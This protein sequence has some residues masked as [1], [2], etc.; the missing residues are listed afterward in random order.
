[1]ISRKPK[2]LSAAVGVAALIAT[3][4]VARTVHMHTGPADPTH[5]SA[6]RAI[7]ANPDQVVPSHRNGILVCGMV[8]S[9]S[10]CEKIEM[11]L[12][13]S[14]DNIDLSSKPTTNI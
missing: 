13:M 3:V 12:P 10:D 14:L 4:A 2:F 1:M 8:T 7:G 5:I 9:A 11:L 6:G